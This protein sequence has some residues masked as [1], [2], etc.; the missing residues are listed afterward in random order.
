MCA[1]IAYAQEK[2]GLLTP[3]D[4]RN[5]IRTAT[6]YGPH[7]IGLAYES[8]HELT[9]F[10]RAVHPEQALYQCNHRIDTMARSS[11]GIAHVRYATVG[12]KTSE[13]A[14]PFVHEN[15]AFCHNGTIPNHKDFGSFPVDSLCLGPLIQQQR[16]GRAHGSV[17]IAWMEVTDTVT[18]SIYRHSQ[19]M[20]ARTFWVEHPKC[21]RS[22]GFVTV[23]ASRLPILNVLPYELVS[24]GKVRNGCA[25]DITPQ[26]LRPKWRGKVENGYNPLLTRRPEL[27]GEFAASYDTDEIGALHL[28]YPKTVP[29]L[30]VRYPSGRIPVV[31]KR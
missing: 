6:A 3:L 29:V 17:G 19:F 11:V 18:L 7:S 14:H 15:V 10:K 26:A 8:K 4:I 24:I 22:G 1:I 25:Y 5:M 16:V 23:M 13:N 9:V 12:E 21:H 27:I 31:A 30:G 28:V 20:H 2:P